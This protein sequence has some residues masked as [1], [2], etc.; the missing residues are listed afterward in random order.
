M[1][2]R[3]VELKEKTVVGITA[4]TNNFSPDMGMV[5]GGLWKTF[6]EGII[7]EISDKANAYTLGIYTDY[8]SDEKGDYTFMTACE[9]TAASGN[10]TLETRKIPAGKYAEFKISGDMNT[11]EQLKEIQKL[12][13]KIWSLNLERSYAYDFEEYRSADPDKADIRIY[14][15]LKG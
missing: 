7:L 13:Q 6:F 10:N 2:Y 5:I 15:G 1:D 11:A 9:V 14:I 4:R 3:I 8:A 12:W